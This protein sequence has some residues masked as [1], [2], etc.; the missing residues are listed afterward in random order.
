[1]HA[2]AV[3]LRVPVFQNSWVLVAAV[4]L[5]TRAAQGGNVTPTVPL[6][7]CNICS[8]TCA[9]W[10]SEE[11][12]FLI[13]KGRPANS[14]GTPLS[15][16]G[17]I[18]P[19]AQNCWISFPGKYAE[20]WLASH[21]WTRD[22]IACVFTAATD[23]GPDLGCS[24]HVHQSMSIQDSIGLHVLAGC[25]W[26]RL[27]DTCQSF[28]SQDAW[29]SSIRSLALLD[30]PFQS[31]CHVLLAVNKNFEQQKPDSIDFRFSYS[32]R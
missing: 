24:A 6:R 22:S 7:T 25:F 30:H 3:N 31:A 11:T 19:G 5:H 16:A 13:P 28:T 23:D 4:R 21:E 10:S 9:K 29:E 17:R 27:L 20:S 26:R 12:L 2:F 15:F 1:M 14:S 32:L 8:Y 18:I